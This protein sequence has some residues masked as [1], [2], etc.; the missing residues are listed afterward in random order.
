MNYCPDCG[1]KVKRSEFQPEK[2]YC[3]QCKQMFEQCPA[4]RTVHVLSAYCEVTGKEM[5]LAKKEQAIREEFNKQPSSIVIRLTT[6]IGILM[7]LNL[8][9]WLNIYP[10]LQDL[11]VLS[12]MPG[13]KI[14]SLLG[15]PASGVSII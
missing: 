14:L 1:G 2:E 12:D 15:G 8:I 3:Q 7:V 6:M 13:F 5:V 9:I 11:P 4:C 10:F